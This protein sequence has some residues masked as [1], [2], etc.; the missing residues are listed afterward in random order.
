MKKNRLL[1]LIC[2]I[3]LAVF[4]SWLIGTCITSKPVYPIYELSKGFTVTI[5]DNRYDNVDITEFYNILDKNKLKKDDV[6]TLSTTIPKTDDIP[7]PA[8]LFRS[9]YT[10]L[11]CYID[12][13]EIY[14]FALDMYEKKQFIGKMYHFISLPL[15]YKNTQLTITMIAGESDAFNN[16][17][18]IKLGSQPDIESQLIHH[19]MAIIATGM[20][21]F[22][23][24]IVFLCITMFFVSSTPDILPLLVGSLFCLNLGPWIM[25]YYNVLAPFFYTRFET[26]IEYFTLYLIVPYCYLLLYFVQK[27]EKKRLFFTLA[28]ISLGIT[29]TQFVLHFIFNIH[30]RATL[31]MYHIDALVSF[32]VLIFYLIRNI[33]YK[34]LSPSGIIQMA[35]LTVFAL[36]EVI[37]LVLY[38]LDGFHIQYSD[39]LAIIVIDSG[40]LFFVMCQIANY[41]LYVTQ[42]Y[43]QKKEYA[44]L[45]HLAYADGLTNMSNR[46]KADKILEDFNKVDTDYCIISIDLNGLKYVNDEFGHPSGDKY[47][48]DFAKV[49]TTTFEANGICAR[50]GGDEFLVLIEDSSDKDIDSLI[51]RMN[52]ALNVMNAIYSEYQRSVATGYAFRHECPE[53]SPSHEVY[54]LADQRMYEKKRKMHE[55]LGIKNRL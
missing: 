6:I 5:N 24:G 23:F 48:K 13:K 45:S 37:H 17:A 41:L 26:Q 33:R 15:D 40:C 28:L 4:V 29:L 36:S 8:L 19:H 47:I 42:S 22:V 53:G 21:L 16:L 46:A 51:G 27:I 7:F 3:A 11:Q 12:D 9:R 25:S 54:L 31:P 55:E 38:T 30:L 35:G 32:V 43:A 20:F 14:S 10:T 2:S 1:P 44:S 52:S 34:E 39:F 49:L 18:A 50:I